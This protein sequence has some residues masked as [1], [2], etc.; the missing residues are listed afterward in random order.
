MSLFKDFRTYNEQILQ[1][2]ADIFNL[3]NTP[4][5]GTP[6]GTAGPTG[7]LIT[8]PRSFQNLTPDARF[9]QFALKY[10]F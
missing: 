3:L 5:W 9:F 8:G 1:F 6:N 4:S 10:S 7:G 2:R